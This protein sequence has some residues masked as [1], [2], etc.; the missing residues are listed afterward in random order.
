M[1]RY[2]PPLLIALLACCTLG[3]WETLAYGFVVAPFAFFW[4]ACPCCD[5]NC[6]IFTDDFSTDRT[7]SD[8]TTV[9][10]TWSVGSGVLTTGSAGAL[11]VE[12][13]AGTTGHGRAKVSGKTSASGGSFRLIGSYVDSDNYL[14]LEVTING[15]SSTAKLWKRE[16]GSNTQLGTTYDFTGSTGTYYDITLCWNGTKALANITDIGVALARFGW[17]QSYTGTGNQAGLGASP[18]GGTT[19]FDNFSFNKHFDDDESCPHCGPLCA[20]CTGGDP[21]TMRWQVVIPTVSNKNCVNCADYAGTYI[22]DDITNLWNPFSEYC[23]WRYYFDSVPCNSDYLRVWLNGSN[24]SITVDILTDSDFGATGFGWSNIGS[25]AGD[26]DGIDELEVAALGT[27]VSND[28][29]PAGTVAI[30]SAI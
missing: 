6:T 27:G 21:P 25:F 28:C 5:G 19:T 18:N 2:L 11:I 29:D 16:T 10:G 15:V 3:V 17:A 30:V 14:F 7:G 13:T 24:S 4:S 26:C 9:S 20:L 12:N 1:L 22:I 23:I 8:Y